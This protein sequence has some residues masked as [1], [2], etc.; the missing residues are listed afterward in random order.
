MKQIKKEKSLNIDD[1][2]LDWDKTIINTK[3]IK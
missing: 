1:T 2:E 3:V